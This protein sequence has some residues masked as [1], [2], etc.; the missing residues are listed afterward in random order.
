MSCDPFIDQHYARHAKHFDNDLV[1]PERIRISESW[2]NDTTADY[3]RHARAYECADLLTHDLNASWLTI[4]DGRWGLDAI[5]IRKKGFTS[6]LATDIRESLLCAAKERGL[7]NNYSIENAEKLS[8]DDRSFDYVFCKESLHHFPRPYV[9]LYE[10]IRVARKAVFI[11]EPNDTYRVDSSEIQGR[12]FRLITTLL[13]RGRQR[14]I[15][16]SEKQKNVNYAVQYNE[17]GWEESGNYVYAIS[18][19]DIEKIALGLNL[20]QIVMKG[21]NDHYV[22][23]CEFEPADE[24]KSAIFQEIVRVVRDKDELCRQNICDS[25][26]LMGGFF[27]ESIDEETRKRFLT[28]GWDVRDLPANPYIQRNTR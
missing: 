22:K 5:R 12:L 20:P 10:M 4:G 13:R 15:S 11:I 21:L 27:L 23:G 19:R 7:I 18:R 2:F 28:S 1:N 9:A 14:S 16:K 3:W 8:F 25:N 24:H 26:L 6:V 17:P